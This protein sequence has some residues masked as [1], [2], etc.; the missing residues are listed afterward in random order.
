V[1]LRRDLVEFSDV[2]VRGAGWH[3]ADTDIHTNGRRRS[4]G[5]GHEHSYPRGDRDQHNY[6]NGDADAESHRHGDG[7]GD[8]ADMPMHDLA[9]DGGPRGSRGE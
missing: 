1:V 9:G 8:A 2:R 6:T 3:A 5:Y 4:H 7:D